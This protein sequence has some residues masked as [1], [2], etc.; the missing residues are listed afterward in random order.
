M[1]LEIFNH[2]DNDLLSEIFIQWQESKLK[3]KEMD[4]ISVEILR[5]F[6]NNPIGSVY[7]IH[8]FL[9]NENKIKIAYK[10]VRKKIK[11]L[12]SL[13]YIIIKGPA[14]KS[15]INDP[16]KNNIKTLDNMHGAIYYKIT[17]FGIFNIFRKKIVD[18]D[19]KKKYKSLFI[20]YEDFFLF[21]NMLFNIFSLKIIKELES[22][23]IWDL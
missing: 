6:I 11:N 1:K 14:D 9:N 3:A 12:S 13:G 7:Q 19:Y 23:F 15:I 17:S 21:K 20:N 18:L 5:Y 4:N 8:K 2:M 10:N 16:N 22:D